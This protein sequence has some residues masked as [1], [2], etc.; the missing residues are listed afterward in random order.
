[1][2]LSN[3]TFTSLKFSLHLFLNAST[4]FM[5]HVREM[6]IMNLTEHCRMRQS[7]GQGNYL[8][9][10]YLCVSVDADDQSV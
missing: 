3:Y 6:K 8:I 9:S 5:C 1:M 4:W 2:L 7:G 10:T